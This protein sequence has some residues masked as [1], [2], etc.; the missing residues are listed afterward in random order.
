MKKTYIISDEDI[1]VLKQ[2]VSQPCIIEKC[3]RAQSPGDYGYLGCGN[4]AHCDRRHQYMAFKA[5]AEAAG[6]WELVQLLYR[7]DAIRAQQQALQKGVVEATAKI[8]GEYGWSV[9]DLINKEL[10]DGQL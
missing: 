2:R 3:S 1:A 4:E 7:I 6:L 9:L 10:F 5:K 8:G